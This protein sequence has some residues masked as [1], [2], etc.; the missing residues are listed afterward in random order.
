MLVLLIVVLIRYPLASLRYRWP[1]SQLPLFFACVRLWKVG[2]PEVFVMTV[3][4]P[5]AAK[6]LECGRIKT[7]LTA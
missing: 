7:T 2:E 4:I 1:E 5:A 6:V 3:A